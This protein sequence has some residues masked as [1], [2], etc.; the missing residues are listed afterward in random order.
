MLQS[1]MLK[2]QEMYVLQ[3]PSQLDGRLQHPRIN[4]QPSQQTSRGM[5]LIIAIIYIFCIPL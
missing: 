3:M 1:P 2:M 5:F 4:V